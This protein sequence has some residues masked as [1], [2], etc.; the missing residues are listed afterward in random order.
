MAPPLTLTLPRSAPVLLLPGQHDRGERL[1]DLEQV[2]VV[3]G[4]AGLGQHLLGGRDR[5]GEHHHRVDAG[6]GE[7]VEPGPRAEA[8]LVGLLLAHDQHG[9]GAVGDLRGVAGGDLAVGLERRLQV[10][11][12]L[13]GG[14]GADALVGGDE[15]VG[16]DD[17]ARLAVEAARP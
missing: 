10:G 3:D 12:R 13:D 8:E 5:T 9:G 7:G 6:E 14:A 11:E 15:L 16:L 2:D 17:L 4:Q 1:V